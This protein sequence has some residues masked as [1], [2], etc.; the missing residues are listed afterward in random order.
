MTGRSRVPLEDVQGPLEDVQDRTQT[1]QALCSDKR[2]VCLW[3]CGYAAGYLP[4]K[5]VPIS[6][7]KYPTEELP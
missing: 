7:R 1:T 4:R 3:T 2:L 6:R 5:Q